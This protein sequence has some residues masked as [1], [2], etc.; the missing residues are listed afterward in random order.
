MEEREVD[1]EEVYAVEPDS[2]EDLEAWLIVW[3]NPGRPAL[4]TLLAE[5]TG[6][7]FVLVSGA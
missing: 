3:L 6:A 4:P 7:V 5:K 2:C 1:E